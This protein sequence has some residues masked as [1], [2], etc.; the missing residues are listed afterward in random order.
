MWSSEVMEAPA[1][2]VGRRGPATGQRPRASFAELAEALYAVRRRCP[3]RA[4]LA[5][6]WMNPK[7][8]IHPVQDALMEGAQPA[9]GIGR[10]VGRAVWCVLAAGRFTITLVAMRWRVRRALAKLRGRHFDVV[11]KTW[12]FGTERRADQRDFYYGDLQR[13]LADRGLTAVLLCGNASRIAWGE[14]DRAHVETSGLCRVPELALAPPLAPALTALGQLRASVRLRWLA[15]RTRDALVRRVS[16]QASVDCLAPSAT[17]FGL[18]YWI[19]RAAVRRW[20]PRALVTLYEG[21]GWEKC[22]WAGA[23]AADRDCLTVGYQHTVVFPHAISLL[24]PQLDHPI[25]AVPDVVA[26]T[27]DRTR[28]LLGPGH[29]GARARLLTLG[30]FRRAGGVKPGRPRP[31]RRTVLVVPEGYLDEEQILFEAAMRVAPAL[32]DHHFILRCHPV[33]PFDRVRPLLAHAPEDL[34]N[35]EVSAVS[36]IEDDYARAS[37]VLY[38]G[39][40]SVLYAVVDGLKPI[41][42]H[43]PHRHD[44]DPLFELTTWRERVG[45]PGELAEAAR[46]YAAAGDERAADEWRSAAD[47]VNAYSVAVDDGAIARFVSA[48]GLAAPAVSR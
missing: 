13:R 21:H 39:S 7:H 15:A 36:A 43:H 4:V 30:T 41:Y 18:Y 38:R 44:I 20:R 33:L 8:P 5:V 46:R 11:L 10:Q 25:P 34:P 9:P 16:V 35:V 29:A 45:S 40:S 3:S 27:G 24:R 17:E 37:V 22:A 14:F 1:V 26:C 42:W 28:D 23:K 48:L 31:G 2:G 32:P 12:C 19:A 6:A 47:Y